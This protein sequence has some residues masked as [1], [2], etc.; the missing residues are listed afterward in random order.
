MIYKEII[1]NN[2]I[3]EENQYNGIIQ[4]NNKN[5]IYIS[6][7][8]N[9]LL[10]AP[11]AVN[12]VRNS[13]IKPAD[14]NTGGIVKYLSE[15][16]KIHEITRIFNKNDDP[17]YS[18]DK[19]SMMYKNEIIN[20]IKR[21]NIKL[22]IDIHG[23]K[24]NQYEIGTNFGINLNQNENI[25][26]ELKKILECHKEVQVDKEFTASNMINIC[27][28]VAKTTNIPCIQLEIP[29]SVR[30]DKEECEKF[31]KLMT[32]FINKQI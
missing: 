1:K 30:T 18:D 29:N 15:N 3:Y 12:Q 9:I 13:E 25:V 11:H 27:K 22:L 21:Y 20:N 4:E 19:I 31:I 5:Y 6:R 7:E 8:N 10:S 16:L 32:E 17:N 2:K 28:V 23:C 26:E 14:I 24:K